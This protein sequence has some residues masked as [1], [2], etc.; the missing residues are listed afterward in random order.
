MEKSERKLYMQFNVLLPQNGKH[1]EEKN[2]A[3]LST[4]VNRMYIKICIFT[5]HSELF[6]MQMHL[7]ILL[8]GHL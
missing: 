1:F 4:S 5:I 2:I 7:F 6:S 8:K 3:K